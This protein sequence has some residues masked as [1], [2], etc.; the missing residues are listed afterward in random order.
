MAVDQYI[1][2]GHKFIKGLALDDQQ[3]AV[4]RANAVQNRTYPHGVKSSVFRD[5]PEVCDVL[6]MPVEEPNAGR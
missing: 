4:L 2:V 5:V 1:E 3:K 6:R